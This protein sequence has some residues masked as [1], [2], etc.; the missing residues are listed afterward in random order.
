LTGRVGILAIAIVF[1]LYLRPW[2]PSA[3]VVAQSEP[4][5]SNARRGNDDSVVV[6]NTEATA[7]AEVQSQ[8]AA[9][10]DSD[11]VVI[12]ND[13]AATPTDASASTVTST[14]VKAAEPM[15][16]AQS[17]AA[18]D[19]DTVVVVNGAA[20]ATDTADGGAATFESAGSS[21]TF[22]AGEIEVTLHRTND[23]E[24]ESPPPPPKRLGALSSL[25]SRFRGKAAPP[26]PAARAPDALD[27]QLRQLDALIRTG[28][29][30]QPGRL[31]TLLALAEK[32]AKRGDPSFEQRQRLRAIEGKIEREKL[33]SVLAQKLAGVEKMVKKDG[34]SED[35]KSTIKKLEDDI[36]D[37]A[38]GVAGKKALSAEAL[39]TDT[40]KVDAIKATLE[41][42]E[43]LEKQHEHEASAKVEADPLV[44]DRKRTKEAASRRDDV[45][46]GSG[47]ISGGSRL[48]TSLLRR[49]RAGRTSSPSEA[50][51]E[52]SSDVDDS[53][54]D[55]IA[56]LKKRLAE[57]TEVKEVKPLRATRRKRV[58]AEAEEE[59]EEEVEAGVSEEEEEEVVIV[60]RPKGGSASSGTR[61]RRGRPKLRGIFRG[62]QT[63]ESKE[64]AEEE[65]P[66]V[67]VVKRGAKG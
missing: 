52:S 43:K 32:T 24:Y 12:V 37:D 20:V 8:S 6:V 67:V 62:T 48:P 14:I 36:M 64:D 18:D 11:S 3:A 13:A 33:G 26:P 42:S 60:R 35:L 38:V 66:D 39:S 5:G 54:D 53:E 30:V 56:S 61:R 25:L 1:L 27:L 44:A 46:K 10:G 58:A 55:E 47:G 9:G 51:S 16:R 59:V 7:T 2:A 57:L 31:A 23:G 4:T 50:Q 29:S 40:S 65:E 15:A 63:E 45:R 19:P 28:K 49:E 21:S 22:S 34:A 17:A 41:E